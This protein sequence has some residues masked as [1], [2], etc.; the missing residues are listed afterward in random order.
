MM[1]TT[2]P[3]STSRFPVYEKWGSQ[4]SGDVTIDGVGSYSTGDLAKTDNTFPTQLQVREF[5]RQGIRNRD[6][7]WL[8]AETNA[9]GSAASAPVVQVQDG[10]EKYPNDQG[11]FAAI[12]D[13]G[14][15]RVLTYRQ[16]MAGGTADLSDFVHLLH[17]NENTYVNA[18]TYM[19]ETW[20]RFVGPLTPDMTTRLANALSSADKGNRLTLRIL[21][22]ML[23]G[24][25]RGKQIKQLLKN[26]GQTFG[27]R[28]AADYVMHMYWTYLKMVART[29]LGVTDDSELAANTA[30]RDAG[31]KGKV[32]ITGNSL[33]A[34]RS[35][36]A[37]M[38]CYYGI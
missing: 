2:W 17:L 1:V 21:S 9:D 34:M 3:D 23:W 4:F 32:W 8:N 38:W 22:Q 14:V 12:Y 6:N 15:D 33:G 20:Q 18:H 16:T 37:A 30:P 26:G 25:N 7:A 13:N 29:A 5:E 36:L 35:Q 11:V 10:S 24:M 28:N 27:A 19:T 31:G